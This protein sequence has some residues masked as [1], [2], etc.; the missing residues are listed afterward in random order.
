ML[1]LGEWSVRSALRAGLLREGDPVFRLFPEVEPIS[2]R[3]RVE[4]D[5]S[6][7]VHNYYAELYGIGGGAVART[8]AEDVPAWYLGKPTTASWITTGAVAAAFGSLVVGAD[9]DDRDDV[10]HLQEIGDATQ[11]LVPFAGLGMAA[12][13]RDWEGSLQ[14]IKATVVQVGTLALLKNLSG[15]SRPNFSNTASFPSGHTAAS[16]LGSSFIHRRYGAKWGIPAHIVASYTGYSRVLS[17]NHFVDDV[18][19]GAALGIMSNLLMT[20]PID[21][22]RLARYEDLERARPWRF[23]WEWGAGSVR[24]NNVRTKPDGTPLDFAFVKEANPTTT[25]ALR[26]ER[27]FGDG[28]R[29]EVAATANPFAIREIDEAPYDIVFAGRLFAEGTSVVTNTQLY[30]WTARYR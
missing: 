23:S 27:D 9:L 30:D 29:H 13:A 21:E 25:A 16:F 1:R 15:K 2:L 28:S 17:Q 12:G 14:L 11:Y 22:D 7:V 26:I 5:P 20:R 6:I 18:L 10:E 24:T 19:S 4:L 8:R 3:V